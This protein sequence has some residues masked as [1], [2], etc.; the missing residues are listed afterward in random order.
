MS[1]RVVAGVVAVPDETIS[2]EDDI[3]LAAGKFVCSKLESHLAQHGHSIPDW[4]HGG[5]DED[6]GVYFESVLNETAFRYQICFFSCPPDAA[7]NQM[8]V[9][10]HVRQP[11]LSWLFRKRA[12]LHFD[13]PMHE[14]MRSFGK[15]F[16]ASR[17]LT[18]SQFESEY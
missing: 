6:W 16:S 17:M 15:L 2:D 13:H 5:C 9:Q 8:V 10:Y 1:D 14:T 18:R 12:E 11:L 7:Q 4:I 3:W